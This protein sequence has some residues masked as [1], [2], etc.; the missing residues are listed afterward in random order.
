MGWGTVTYNSPLKKYLTCVTDGWPSC[1]K[2][3]SYIL[4]ADAITG[5]Y[6]PITYMK[7]FGE[8]AYFLNFP[9][10]FISQDGRTLWLCYSGNYAVGPMFND[11]D[12]HEN[13]PG[14]H[15]GLVMQEVVLVTPDSNEDDK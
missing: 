10:K 1:G 11:L 9:T 13:S 15:Y 5:P 7:D 4:E 3:S 8:Q 6:K 12:I 2:M 14:S